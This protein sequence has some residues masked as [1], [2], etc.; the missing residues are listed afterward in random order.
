M[1]LMLQQPTIPD[2]ATKPAFKQ[3]EKVIINGEDEDDDVSIVPPPVDR[4]SKA[5]AL[6]SIQLKPGQRLFSEVLEAEKDLAEDSLRLEQSQLSMEREWDALRQKRERAAEEDMR[7]ELLRR[8]EKLLERLRRM[9]KDKEEKEK[10]N[11]DLRIQLQALKLTEHRQD[12]ETAADQIREKTIREKDRQR[13]NLKAQVE[14]MRSQR[15]QQE[16]M[17]VMRERYSKELVIDDDDDEGD[18]SSSDAPMP[19]AGYSGVT[20]EDHLNAN[21]SARPS[22]DRTAKPQA[23]S[24]FLV[25]R[26][27]KPQPKMLGPPCARPSLTGLKNLG[28]TCYMNSVL[29]CLTNFTLP[30]SYFLKEIF[31]RDLNEKSKTRG[32]VAKEYAQVTKRLWSGEYQ[33][34][35]PDAMKKVAGKFDQMFS[36]SGQQDA[37]EFFSKLMEWLHEELNE[38][39]GDKHLPVQDFNKMSDFDGAEAAWEEYTKTVARSFII[40]TFYGQWVSTLTCRTCGWRSAKYDP[41]ME[42]TIQLPTDSN[43]SVSF[44]DGMMDLLKQDQVEYVCES[45]KRQNWCTKQLQ[46]VKLPL[47]LSVHFVRFYQ[48][49]YSYR[50]ILRS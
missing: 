19:L 39:R 33:M 2:R 5:K 28:N 47:I 40:E 34:I 13:E 31:R 38:V 37:H 16:E 14:K 30:S 15:K 36:G 11:E 41:F 3:P 26:H 25:P 21:V 24:P 32:Q 22:I 48:V 42:L 7:N 49:R 23:R 10:E 17:E 27:T 8:E 6:L 12:H 4:S 43:H 45:C 29:Q 50:C 1:A 9:A 46:I 35:S 20:D 18:S 44:H